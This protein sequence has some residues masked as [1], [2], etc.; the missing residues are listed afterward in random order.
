[1]SPIAGIDYTKAAAPAATGHARTSPDR[2][3]SA[4]AVVNNSSVHEKGPT[5]EYKIL[6]MIDALSSRIERTET[7]QIRID[8][9]ERMRGEIERSLFTSVLGTNV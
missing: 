3:I 4:P 6:T 5:K 8:E 7:S 9:D 2:P 1:M